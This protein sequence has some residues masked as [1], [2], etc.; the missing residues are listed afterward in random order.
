MSRKPFL[1]TYRGCSWSIGYQTLRFANP[2]LA[3]KVAQVIAIWAH[4][5][6]N[7]AI[8]LGCLLKAE[9]DAALGVFA[10]LR[11]FRSQEDVIIGAATAVLDEAEVDLVR[12]C[13]AAIKTGRRTRDDFAHGIWGQTGGQT[14]MGS[15]GPLIWLEA[16]HFAPWNTRAILNN[17]AT[18]MHPE[19]EPH[20]FVYTREDLDAAIAVL[21]T[22]F[23]ISFHMALYCAWNP[24][25]AGETRETLSDRL[26]AEPLVRQALNHQRSRSGSQ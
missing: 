3:S 16:K 26:K 5:E 14:G 20:L 13:L 22:S 18:S 2:E 7:L 17:G 11:G 9:S 19:L 21:E 8:T 23:N 10:A 6:H 15:D 1:P 4:A 25:R 12:A 24:G